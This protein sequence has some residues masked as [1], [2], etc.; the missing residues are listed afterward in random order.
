MYDKLTSGWFYWSYDRTDWGLHNE[1]WEDLKKTDVLVRPYPQKIAGSQLM[2]SWHPGEQIF[3]LSYNY[4]PVGD[5]HENPDQYSVTEVYLPP[6]SWPGGW[7]LN[8]HGVEISHSF[9]PETN[10]L[11]IQPQFS[12][13]VRISI[14]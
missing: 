6:R 10:I 2:F 9:D 14:D 11:S 8:N 3:S 13:E 12:G 4:S 1:D 7:K 5:S